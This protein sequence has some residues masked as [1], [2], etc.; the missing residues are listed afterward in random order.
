MVIV[1]TPFVAS[2]TATLA[3]GEWVPPDEL[4]ELIVFLSSGKVRHLT[5]ATLDVNGASYVR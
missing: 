2:V 1:T 3:M 4:A 5:G